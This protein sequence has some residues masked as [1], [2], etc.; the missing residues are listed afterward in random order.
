MLTGAM[1]GS[2]TGT[3]ADNSSGTKLKGAYITLKSDSTAVAHS[4][5]DGAFTLS[6][7]KSYS[8][9]D[10]LVV[11]MQGYK[12]ALQGITSYTETGITIKLSASNPW[13]PSGSLTHSGSMVKILAKGYDFEMGQPDPTADNT[14]VNDGSEISEQP[15]HTVNFT[16]DFWMDTTEVTQKLFD[17]VMLKVYDSASVGKR[18]YYKSLVSMGSWKSTYGLGDNYPVYYVSWGDIALFC[19]ARSKLDGLDT[20][21]TYDSVNNVRIGQTCSLVGAISDITKK[22]YR[23]PTEAEWEYACKGGTS[24]DFFWG[25]NFDSYPVISS[26]TTEI[27]NYAVWYAT[28]GGFAVGS[29][30]FGIHPV[31]TTTPNPYGLYDMTGNVSEYCNDYQA[32]YDYGI[33]IDPTGPSSGE[34]NPV[35]GGNWQNYAV[36]LRSADRNVKTGNYV[37]YSCGFRTVKTLSNT[38]IKQSNVSR[39]AS[40]YSAYI[41]NNRIV[42][43]T[44]GLSRNAVVDVY[45]VNGVRLSSMKLTNLAAGSHSAALPKTAS[46]IYFVKLTIGN[47]SYIVKMASAAKNLIK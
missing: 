9:P 13:V 20:I 44:T 19:N 40:S 23:L 1:A 15:V 17:S 6:E 22:G 29:T 28:A 2:L 41:K 36:K 16:H 11:V 38:G 43:S 5:A 21:Y 45:S 34:S 31:A 18:K 42:F 39:K 8:S 26:D 24:T 47:E 35:R 33:V 3:V 12:N 7:S 27:D 10:S 32:A 46:G 14:L 37:W 25:K 4:D 30:G